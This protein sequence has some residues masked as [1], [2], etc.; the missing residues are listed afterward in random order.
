[1]IITD[2]AYSIYLKTARIVKN[3][4]LVVVGVDFVVVCGGFVKVEDVGGVTVVVFV[5]CGGV[6]VVGGGKVVVVVGGDR[7]VMVVV[8]G[9][10]IIVVGLVVVVADLVVVLVVGGGVVV[11]E[12]GHGCVL[13]DSLPKN[14]PTHCCPPLAGVGLVHDR[15]R[16]LNPPPQVTVHCD[17][18]CQLDHSPFTGHGFVLQCS[19][20]SDFP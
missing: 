8:G 15:V 1:M 16:T 7:E 4:F 3:F 17:G 11:K 6:V 14:K 5:G 2:N 9:C 19:L 12:A 18:F 13:Q 20:L 10:K